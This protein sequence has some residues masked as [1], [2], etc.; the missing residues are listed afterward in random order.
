MAMSPSVAADSSGSPIAAAGKSR[1]VVIRGMKIDMQYP[2]YPGKNYLGRTDDKPVDI[3][4]DDQEA[5]DR[6]WCSRQHAVITLEN[7]QLTIE[8]LN[9]LNGSFV[10]RARVYPGQAKELREND[11]IQIGTVHMK[12]LL[13]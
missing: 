12:L 10:N 9:S 3:D 7:G 13:S 2:L 8:D 6:I 5:P 4:L 1:L 11:V